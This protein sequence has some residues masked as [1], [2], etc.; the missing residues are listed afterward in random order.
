M[1]PLENQIVT[2]FMVIIG[3]LLKIRGHIFCL[4]KGFLNILYLLVRRNSIGKRNVWMVELMASVSYLINVCAY[5]NNELCVPYHVTHNTEWYCTLWCDHAAI[6]V[7]IYITV[8]SPVF[9]LYVWLYRW[10]YS[11]LC[12]NI[13]N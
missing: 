10:N 11:S 12:T 2:R 6:R 8:N 9:Y 1:S 7:Y 5:C 3:K 13:I 4:D